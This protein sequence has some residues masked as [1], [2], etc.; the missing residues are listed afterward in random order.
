MPKLFF[1]SICLLL[2]YSSFSQDI[3]RWTE[4]QKAAYSEN[5][6]DSRL[7]DMEMFQEDL[8]FFLEGND[9][10]TSVAIR[11]IPSPVPVYD[12]GYVS[13]R[14]IQIEIAKKTLSGYTIAYANDDYRKQDF[15]QAKALYHTYFNLLVLSSK[16]AAENRATATVSR[17]YP[18]YLSTGKQDVAK[19]SI[20]WVQM[21]MAGGENF[22]IISQRYFD[23]N[24]GRTILI[25]EQEDGSI[26]FLQL[27]DSPNDL[28]SDDIRSGKPLKEIEDYLGRLKTDPKV[29]AF[30]TRKGTID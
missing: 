16:K 27:K 11:E 8:D 13:L 6:Q 18:H 21:H 17:N 28:F 10:P 19:G 2:A 5:R 12:W 4:Q 9:W 29:K 15:S 22:A 26:R 7:W 14:G 23:L 1:C 3:Q 24:Y 20:D 30:L 25:A